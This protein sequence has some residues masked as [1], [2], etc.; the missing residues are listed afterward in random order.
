MRGWRGL[1]GT[2][3]P[4]PTWNP[5]TPWTHGPEPAWNPWA[6]AC[7]LSLPGLR[8]AE[9]AAC[10]KS[11]LS[12]DASVGRDEETRYAYPNDCSQLTAS[13]STPP[14][15]IKIRTGF[16]SI[17]RILFL[18]TRLFRQFPISHAQSECSQLTHLSRGC[19][20]RNIHGTQT[21]HR[22][23]WAVHQISQTKTRTRNGWEHQGRA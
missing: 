19:P 6:G 1:R 20:V 11:W 17:D 4:E 13:F 8:L 15:A 12:G 21:G 7:S 18:C 16:Q 23:S 14:L 3:G 22:E 9:P 2:H 5:W 10:S